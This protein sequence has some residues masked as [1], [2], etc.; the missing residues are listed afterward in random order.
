MATPTERIRGICDDRGIP[1]SKIE[2]DVGVSNGYL[3]P[4]KTKMIPADRLY[5]FAKYLEVSMEYLLTG[6]EEKPPI[7]KD[8]GL[9]EDEQSLISLY[10]GLSQDQQ[11]MIIAQLQ[12]L[13]QLKKAPGSPGESQ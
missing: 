6:K 3:N 12:G 10:R 11:T 13:A 9:S 4:Q 8:G 5:R 1:I 2:K 7:P